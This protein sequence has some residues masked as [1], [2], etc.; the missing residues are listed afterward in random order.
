MAYI[1]AH[2]GAGSAL[3]HNIAAPFIA[4]GNALI[5]LGEANSRVKQAEFLQ[6]LSDEQLA[7]RGLTRDEIARHVFKD[8]YY[9]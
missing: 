2:S 3:L 6:S 5:R 4:L 9:V 7:A 1:T 8:V